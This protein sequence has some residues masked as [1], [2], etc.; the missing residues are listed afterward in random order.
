MI[1]LL[2]LFDMRV[3]WPPFNLSEISL[4]CLGLRITGFEYMENLTKSTLLF[5]KQSSFLMVSSNIHKEFRKKNL[6]LFLVGKIKSD[7]ISKILFRILYK[8]IENV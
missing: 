2:P 7:N 6:K 4:L 5:D 8:I 3:C 1:V